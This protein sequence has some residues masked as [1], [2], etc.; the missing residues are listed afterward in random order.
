MDPAGRTSLARRLLRFP[1]RIRSGNAPR[2]T[3]TPEAE[4]LEAIGRIAVNWS[5][6]EIASGL[7]LMELVGSHDETLAQAVVAG[8]RVENVW[9]T[10]E[11]L[12]AAHDD[13]DDLLDTFVRWR[14]RANVQRRRRNEVIHSGWSLSE[15]DDTLAATDMM[16]R[17]AKRGARSDLFPEGV[18]QLEQLARN[19]AGLEDSLIELHAAFSSRMRPP[20]GTNSHN[21]HTS[22]INP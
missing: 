18:P 5:S 16:S 19:I 20:P 21:P 12:L 14:Q 13:T 3:A 11:A 7:V 22:T 2:P 6:V 9:E 10:I 4:L 1:G 17:R 8:Q 15:S